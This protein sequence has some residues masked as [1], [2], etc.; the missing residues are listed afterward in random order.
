MK[1]WEIPEINELSV[2]DTTKPSD[3]SKG[4][5]PYKKDCPCKWCRDY[6]AGI[7]PPGTEPPELD[8]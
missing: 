8:S 6:R 2:K 3:K 5:E 7:I 1:N 4:H